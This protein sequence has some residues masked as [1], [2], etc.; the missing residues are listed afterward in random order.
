MR[1]IYLDHNAT[2]PLHPEV[3]DAMLPFLRDSYGNASSIHY[4]GR[5]ARAAVD[6][7]RERLA[8]LLGAKPSEIIFTSGGTESNN[9]AIKGGSFYS[10]SRGKHIVTSA[11]EHHAVLHTCQYL[12]RRH[13]FEVTYVPVDTDC[14]IDPAAVREAIRPDTVLVS[15]MAANNETGTVQPLAEI[16]KLCRE[17]GVPL[18]TDAVQTFGKIPTLPGDWNADLLSISAHKFYG[19]KGAGLLYVRSGT[20]LDPTEHGGSQENERRGG[21]ENV[22]GIVG[23]AEGAEL[24]VGKMAG[25]A[26]RLFQL[27]ER[28]WG[29]ISTRI[30][31]VYRNG[32]PQKR[33][34]NTLHICCENCEGEGLLFGL[35]LEGVAVSS[36][37]ACAVGSLEVSHVLLAMGRSA[38]L[39]EAAV[40]FSFGHENT[41]ADIPETTA[42][43]ARV[44]ERLRSFRPGQ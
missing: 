35:D 43:L 22:A 13:G 2:T 34:P 29:E 28:L 31:G 12:Q 41:E 8:V 38:E 11:I 44:I 25:E 10:Q 1:R 40:R 23:M 33:V 5:E 36:G 18:H 14:L 39:A 27:T 20:R 7:A 30:T 17:R 4:W 15:V 19:P 3:L 26:H 16:G 24:A 37:S 6:D 42:A 21:T 32:H 9:L